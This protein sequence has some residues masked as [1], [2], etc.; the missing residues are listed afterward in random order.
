MSFAVLQADCL[1][2][3]YGTE[4]MADQLFDFD[5]R[6][7]ECGELLV[8]HD[9]EEADDGAVWTSERPTIADSE[10]QRTRAD[11]DDPYAL[12][13]Q[14]LDPTVGTQPVPKRFRAEDQ[15]GELDALE[16]ALGESQRTRSPSGRL[17]PKLR[18]EEPAPRDLDPADELPAELEDELPAELE[19]EVLEDEDLEDE[20]LDDTRGILSD[21]AAP[22]A[23]DVDARTSLPEAHL[24]EGVSP[25]T[26]PL[27]SWDGGNTQEVGALA[28]QNVRARGLPPLDVGPE[29]LLD[30][31][32]APLLLEEAAAPATAAEELDVPTMAVSTTVGRGSRSFDADPARLIAA[33]P[34]QELGAH[35]LAAHEMSVREVPVLEP[36][37]RRGVPRPEPEALADL[38]GEGPE[39]DTARLFPKDVDWL[40]LLDDRLSEGQEEAPPE[41]LDPETGRYVIRVPKTAADRLE[42]PQAV[43]RMQETL[44]SSGAAALEQLLLG[45]TASDS[46][47]AQR[48]RGADEDEPPTAAFHRDPP[49]LPGLEPARPAERTRSWGNDALVETLDQGAAAP[50]PPPRETSPSGEVRRRRAIEQFHRADLDPALVCA[51]DVNSAEAEH[52]RQLYQRV[53][54]AKNGASPRVILV[55]S[56]RAGEGKTT[57]ASNLAIVGA[58]IPEGGALLIDADARGRGVLRAFGQRA[59]TDGLLEALQTGQDPERFVVRFA[60]KELD[61]V[62]LGLRGSDAIELIASDRMGAFVDRVRG[63]YPR[64]SILIDSSPV[65]GSADPLVLSR[66]V[67]AVVLVVR[68][69]VT[70]RED[71]E[72]ALDLIG[73]QRVLG[74]VLND[75]AVGA[76]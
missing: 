64:H 76:A 10:D 66:M 17:A 16:L 47:V 4:V 14:S 50:P 1:A 52:F 15:S 69:G 55:T 74:V 28:H 40:A 2:C 62:P 61:V 31:D 63:L 58:R 11:T 13:A 12:A 29:D 19:D 48:F 30:E 38:V 36:G 70:P 49:P 26:A 68:A 37:S 51:R 24:L 56:A 18:A 75:A 54:H 8:L 33:P 53:F 44:E 60:L 39:L 73:R 9:D 3:G 5:T 27:P 46:R 45:G 23:E 71:V 7:P 43:E 6:C 72:R 35:E 34:G 21:R 41:G 22:L 59:T 32:D 25:H 67:D 20:E 65:L 57:V 42:D